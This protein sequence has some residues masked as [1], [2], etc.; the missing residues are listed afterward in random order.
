MA[1]KGRQARIKVV[2]FLEDMRSGLDDPCLMKKYDLSEIGLTQV[3]GELVRGGFISASQLAERSKI[4]DSQI[5]RAFVD[6][7]EGIEILD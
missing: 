4:R 6:A 1:K 3:F 2:E 7:K 5:T